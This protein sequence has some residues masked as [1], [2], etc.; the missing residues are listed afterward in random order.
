[1]PLSLDAPGDPLHAWSGFT[2]VI[3]QC[4]PESR[5]TLE[6]RSADP[7]ESP[8]IRP[9]YMSHERD[10]KVMVEGVRIAREIHARA[11]FSDLAE[12]EV[13]LGPEVRTDEQVLD[14]MAPRRTP[15]GLR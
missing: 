3:W 8:R 11:P 4:H 1:M 10:R 2:T 14:G 7:D 9:N 5:G 13:L 15:S 12:A 6:I